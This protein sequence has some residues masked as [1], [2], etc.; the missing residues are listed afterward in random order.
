MRGFMNSLYTYIVNP[1]NEF[2]DDDVIILVYH[3][4]CQCTKTLLLTG[5]YLSKTLLLTGK[6]L[7][8]TLLLTGTYLSK[9]FSEG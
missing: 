2:Y 4:T 1:S 8:K 7:S 9:T 5:T 6:Y 3:Y